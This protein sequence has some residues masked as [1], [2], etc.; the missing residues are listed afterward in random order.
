MK[1][2]FVV[3]ELNFFIRN[4]IN[5][6]KRI[7]EFHEVTLIADASK[8]NQTDIEQIGKMGIKL[9]VLNRNKS[10]GKVFAYLSFIFSLMLLIRKIKPEYIFYVTLELSFFGSLI[11]YF[12]PTRK[13]IFIITGLGTFFFKEEV[14]YKVFDRVLHGS[15]LLLSALK[16]NVRFVFLN[17]PDEELLLKRYQINP[18]HSQIIHGEGIDRLEFRYFERQVSTIK[19]LLASRLIKSKGIESFVHSAIQI[20]QKYPQVKLVM[21]CI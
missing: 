20:K 18:S 12:I 17:F 6:V 5:L 9:H 3:N 2:L 11:S 15:F 21:F 14:R 10:G 4:H 8:S 13:T 7:S 19:F 1:V 16:Q